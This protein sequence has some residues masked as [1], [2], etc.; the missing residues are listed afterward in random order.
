[1]PLK[2]KIQAEKGEKFINELSLEIGGGTDKSK[3]GRILLSVFKTLRNHL[4]LEENFHL[5]SQLPMA[6]KPVYIDGWRP[7]HKQIVSNT[8]IGFIEEVLECE[9]S[10][11][12]RDTDIEDVEFAV[13][14]VFNVMRNYVSVGEF[15]DIEAV[16]PTQLK[17]LVRESNYNF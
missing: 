9:G 14:A 4:T 2:F 16:L 10:Y 15:E 5:L 1:M 3:A 17:A 11:F 13:L 12:W 6:L 8:R 7:S